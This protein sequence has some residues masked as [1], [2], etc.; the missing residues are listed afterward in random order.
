MGTGLSLL[1]H[2]F[3]QPPCLCYFLKF[4]PLKADVYLN[5]ITSYGYVRIMY[6][7]TLWRFHRT[8]VAIEKRQCVPFVLLLIYIKLST[9]KNCLLLPRKQKNRFQLHTLEVTDY[10][11]LLLATQ[12]YLSA[13]YFYP[14]LTKFEISWKEF[15]KVPHIK[16]HKNLSSGRCADTWSQIDWQKDMTKLI[17][18]FRFLWKQ[19]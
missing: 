16:F 2:N 14:I 18:A 17:G 4:N 9:I 7:V 15:M 10:F 19:A 6:N 1:L 8:T 3:V 11:I 13:R 5:Y 12:T